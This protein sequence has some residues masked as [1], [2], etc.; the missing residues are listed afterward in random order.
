M[1][2]YL[3]KPGG[4]WTLEPWK[5]SVPVYENPF[6]LP[7]DREEIIDAMTTTNNNSLTSQL[8]TPMRRI[9]HS[10]LVLVDDVVFSYQ[11]YWL[12]LKSPGPTGGFMG[13][14]CLLAS[15]NTITKIT[16]DAKRE[17]SNS[18]PMIEQQRKKQGNKNEDND[19]KDV[20]EEED[21]D[22]EEEEPDDG[23]GM[24]DE[25]AAVP[26]ESREDAAT[27]FC[28]EDEDKEVMR[29]LRTGLVYPSSKT[30]QLLES[31]EDGLNPPVSLPIGS[32]PVFCRICRDG[33]HD[34]ED[35]E[36]ENNNVNNNPA[37]T[38]NN[39][40]VVENPLLAPC[41]CSGSM[42]FVHYLCVE[43]WRCRSRHPAARN[44]THCETCFF[45]YALP[46]PSSRPQVEEE[47]LEA[48][49]PHVMQALRNPHLG[50]QIGAALVRKRWLRP[51]APVLF[52]PLVALYCRAR[53]LL[54]KRGVSRRRWACSLCRRR[55]RW[56][57]VR[58]L[59]SY[60]CS[61]QCQNVSWHIVHKHVCYK[62]S[63]FWWS[64]VVYGCIF[65]LA[66]PGVL[67]DP[68]LYD[69]ALSVIPP[70]FYVMAVLGGAMASAWKKTAGM[71]IRGRLLELVVLLFTVWL[72]TISWG[73]VWAFFGKDSS[74]I[75]V[76]GRWYKNTDSTLWS[77][78]VHR[79][80]LAPAKTY[81]LFWDSLA[82]RNEPLRSL[83]C[84]SDEANSCFPHLSRASP[85]AILESPACTAD[86]ELVSGLWMSAGTT[87]LAGALWRKRRQYLHQ[88]EN[89]NNNR[90]PHQD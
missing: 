44:G 80:L 26:E 46:P 47:W 33:L 58:C 63:R 40:N 86:L 59:R 49:P 18:S 14:I 68:L 77:D 72:V 69:L 55:A 64:C 76:F 24:D 87:L 43:Q 25:S 61:R 85:F 66:L 89:N 52:S 83:L 12:R 16:D 75:G 10:E 27:G 22:D 73:L 78:L 21:D 42:A 51:L 50:W 29:C 57:C 17:S 38:N 23:M 32:Q 62:P 70:S 8:P 31:Y 81:F 37:N 13:Y 9:R 41:E 79:F 53:R 48:M 45:P 54:K 5:R 65:L 71:D 56:K 39:N 60:Y 15:E 11:N 28:P 90:R 4:V 74:C 6:P 19:D 88:L 1:P 35:G 7:M 84:T 82:Q 20:K 67:T 36:Q 34:T 30:L 2:V 3:C